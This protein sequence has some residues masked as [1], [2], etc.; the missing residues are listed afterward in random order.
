MADTVEQLRSKLDEASRKAKAAYRAI[1][2]SES[3]NKSSLEQQYNFAKQNNTKDLQQIEQKYIKAQEEYAKLQKTVDDLNSQIKAAEK[4]ATESKAKTKSQ[5]AAKAAYSKALKDLSDAEKFINTYGGDKKYTDAYNAAKNAFDAASKAGVMGL[6]VLPQQKIPVLD[7][8]KDTTGTGKD[9]KQQQTP[10]TYTEFLD[11]LADPKNKQQLIDV[12][13]NLIKNFGWNGKADG[14][15]T[16]SFQNALQNI[17]QARIGL[18]KSLQSDLRSFIVKPTISIQGIIGKGGAGGGTT[19]TTD[20]TKSVEKMTQADI[21]A[22]INK[23]AQDILGRELTA[24]DK[25]SG[26]YK[27]LND[28][29]QKMINEGTTYKDVTTRGAAGSTTSRVITPGFT[30]EKAGQ[31]IQSTLKTADP[32]SLARKERVDFMSWMFNNLGGR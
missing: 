23:N 27:N 12:Q 4:A 24:Q 2:F 8:K 13:K 29:I 7:L 6:Q 32:E 19:T 18:P 3:F 11:I 28:G 26:W 25:A 31:M 20:V 10:A 30:Q 22:L 16:V 17:E 14:Q 5:D 21:D 15:W 9:Q 1:H